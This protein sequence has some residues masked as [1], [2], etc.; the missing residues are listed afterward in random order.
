MYTDFF[1][2]RDLPFR[3]TPDSRFYFDSR[4]HH[5]ALSYLI[6]GLH[7]AEGF[8]IITGEVG[9]GKTILVDHLLSRPELT[10]HRICQISTTQLEP[11]DLLRM[12]ATGFGQPT[13]G[14][15][16]AGLLTG[17]QHALIAVHRQDCQPLIVVDEAQNLSLQALEELRMLSNLQADSKPL[18]QTLLVGQP[19]LRH[20]LAKPEYEQL[21]QRVIATCHLDP[22]RADDTRA[23]VEH[24]LECVGWTGDP[25]INSDVFQ[26]AFHASGGL[27]RRLNVLFDRLLLFAFLEEMHAID[28]PTV[29]RV[30][31]EMTREGLLPMLRQALRNGGPA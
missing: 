28:R 8:V 18:V 27:P 17:L 6:Y 11:D 22:L 14:I 31:G 13:D 19:Q 12:V 2:L 9:A 3:L 10:R 5:R 25:Q 1:G 20:A 7:K 30:I 26:V 24:R 23:Y 16:K 15:A 29:E 21:A 4:T